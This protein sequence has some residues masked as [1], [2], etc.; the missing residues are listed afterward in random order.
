M[1]KKFITQLSLLSAALLAVNAQALEFGKPITTSIGI[2]N[3]GNTLLAT[4]AKKDV[5]V[6]NIILTPKQRQTLMGY[7][8]TKTLKKI[9]T[10]AAINLPTSI[11]LGMNNV[12]VLDQGRHGS[13]VTFATTAAIDAVI[14]KGDYVSPL[15]NLQLGSY[16]ENKGYMASGWN[17]SM[18]PWVL[19]QMMRFGIVST[20][21]QQHQSCAHVTQYPIDDASYE[22]NPMS[23]DEYKSMSENI[24]DKLAPV[25]LMNAVDRF[26][27]KFANT[28]EMD[29]VITR[30]KQALVRG[31]RVTFGTFLLIAPLSES[32]SGAGACASYH[33]NQD[34]WALTSDLNS[35]L[36]FTGGHEMVIMGYDDNAEAI[37][38]NGG[39]HK[40][41]FIL[42][43]SWGDNVGDHGNFYMTYDYF[44][45]FAD[46]AQEISQFRA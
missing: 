20:D 40:G 18:G 9:G 11:N 45:K 33:T 38:H 1:K 44:K 8:P 41:L 35:P 27:S 26:E 21:K 43:N 42:R 46:E 34:T 15:C 36:L 24:S 28:D 13:C 30:V 6:M 14:G 22:G 37:D 2:T 5:V 32:C 23:L 19:D 3:S 29:N 17:G 10:K 25:Y 39:R 12:P 7:H 16:L 4:K 31:N